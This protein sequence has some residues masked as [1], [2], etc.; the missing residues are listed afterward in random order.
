[1]FYTPLLR[2]IWTWLGII[3][4]TKKNFI[5]YLESGYSCIIVPGGAQEIVHM[6]HGS[7]VCLMPRIIAFIDNNAYPLEACSTP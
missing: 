1:M 4:A 5:S 7:E 6:E 3:P 2:Q